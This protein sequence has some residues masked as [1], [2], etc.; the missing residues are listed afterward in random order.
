MPLRKAN[1]L[2]GRE[3]G[4]KTD[5]ANVRKKRQ[6]NES[7]PEEVQSK[8]PRVRSTQKYKAILEKVKERD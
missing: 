1:R 2:K 8:Q 4:R 6:R 7:A 3:T 5:L